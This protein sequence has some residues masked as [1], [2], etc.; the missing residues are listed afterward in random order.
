MSSVLC[1][2][3]HVSLRDPFIQEPSDMTSLLSLLKGN[4]V[5]LISRVRD[6][7]VC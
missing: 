4:R 2:C 3:S 6:E 1:H 7:G 5:I